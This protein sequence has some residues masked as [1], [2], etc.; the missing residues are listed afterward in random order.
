M[1]VERPRRGRLFPDRWIGES[2]VHVFITDSIRWL[3]TMGVSSRWKERA[4]WG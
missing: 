2:H 3:S 1:P 4:N